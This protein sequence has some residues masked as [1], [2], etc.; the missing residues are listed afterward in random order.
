MQRPT[1]IIVFAILCLIMGVSSAFKNLTEAAL[2]LAGPGM[3]EQMIAMMEAQGQGLSESDKQTFEMQIQALKQ[4]VYR[5]VQ[6]IE[7]SAGL[8]MAVVLVIASIGLFRDRLWSIRLARWWAMFGLV[9]AVV[10][11]VLNVNYILPL[12]PELSGSRGMGLASALVMLPLLWALPVLILTVLSRPVVVDYLKTRAEQTRPRSYQE[13]VQSAGNQHSAPPPDSSD[14]APGP[15]SQ[16]S[17]RDDPWN[18]PSSR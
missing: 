2:S 16:D 10:T 18:D 1:R 9:S 11:T 5:A 12:T 3:L 17:W 15:P 13:V 4:P 7:S 6:G 8:V 14:P